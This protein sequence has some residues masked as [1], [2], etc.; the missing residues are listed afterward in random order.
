MPSKN[1]P[2]CACLSPMRGRVFDIQSDA[3][4]AFSESSLAYSWACWCYSTAATAASSPEFSLIIHIHDQIRRDRL[5]ISHHWEQSNFHQAFILF[6][7]HLYALFAN[8]LC[9]EPRV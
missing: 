7:A 9:F 8:L 5:I 3:L 1:A 6:E 4:S 2:T